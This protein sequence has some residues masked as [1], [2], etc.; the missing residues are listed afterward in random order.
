MNLLHSEGFAFIRML[1]LTAL[2][3]ASITD[4]HRRRI[5]NWLTFS[6]ALAAIIAHGVYGGLFAAGASLLAFLAWF[7]LGFLYYRTLAGKEIGAGDI[8]MIMAIGAC[9]G[10]LPAAHV[11]FVSLVLLILW[12]FVRW[13]VTG[14][15]REN[16]S[17]FFKF[18]WVTATPNTEK[19]HFQP[20]GMVD[21]TPHAPFMLLSA[22]LCYY[23]RQ[24]GILF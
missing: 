20:V 19:I 7:A 13:V 14:T 6:T 23:L 9:L 2:V 3:L 15:A 24:K 10:F 12:L 4:L 1:L 16:F 22:L 11:T 8:K 21:R 5:P 17:R 18:L